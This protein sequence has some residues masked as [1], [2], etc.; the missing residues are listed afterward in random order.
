MINL[1]KK[2]TIVVQCALTEGM[3]NH[4][5]NAITMS[6][7]FWALLLLA[8]IYPDYWYCFTIDKRLRY[9]H[10][11]RNYCFTVLSPNRLEI[12]L[13]YIVLTS[14]LNRKPLGM[15][16]WSMEWLFLFI[17]GILG[18]LQGLAYSKR[19]PNTGHRWSPI[20]TTVPWTWWRVESSPQVGSICCFL[21]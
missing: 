1:Q 17:A 11:N 4:I 10:F 20:S 21:E 14:F 8:R 19:W 18:T 16:E 7:L 9:W 6:S 3:A 15:N 5:E 13:S 2:D 12:L